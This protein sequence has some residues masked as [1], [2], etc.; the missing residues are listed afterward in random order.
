MRCPK[1]SKEVAENAAFC[2]YCGATIGKKEESFSVDEAIS[3]TK[4]SRKKKGIGLKILLTFSIIAIIFGSGLGFLTG[5][6]I[7]NWREC[8][9]LGSFTWT[10]PSE[11]IVQFDDEQEGMGG[12]SKESTPLPTDGVETKE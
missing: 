7:I 1:C 3:I 11:G 9:P 5:R 4:K 12:E 8:I 6:G 10:D 2:G